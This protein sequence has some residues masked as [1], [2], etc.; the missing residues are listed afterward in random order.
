MQAA[1]GGPGEYFRRV[2]G[3]EGGPS[4]SE[5]PAGRLAG[6]PSSSRRPP[7]RWRDARGVQAVRPRHRRA[8]RLPWCRVRRVL[9]LRSPSGPPR[10]LARPRP[11]P[12]PCR[13]VSRRRARLAT[14]CLPSRASRPPPG[15]GGPPALACTSTGSRTA[16]SPCWTG[17][18]TAAA[19]RSRS[20]PPSHPPTRPLAAM[21]PRL[22]PISA[23]TWRPSTASSG[24][25][26]RGSRS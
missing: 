11:W 25:P 10:Q 21:T 18:S 9:A 22:P 8:A 15:A 2:Q 24:C 4:G 5:L 23:R 3:V 6:S 13:P 26:P 1:A 12:R 19:K 20:F 17:G 7:W 14:A 16:S